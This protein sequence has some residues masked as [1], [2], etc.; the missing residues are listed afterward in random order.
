MSIN[1]LFLRHPIVYD[2]RAKSDLY[3]LDPNHYS[4]KAVLVF[5]I[6]FVILV[7]DFLYSRLVNDH[8][9]KFV[10]SDYL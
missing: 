5:E 7:T 8:Q 1:T 4:A 6:T 3:S 9:A 10:L 2:K